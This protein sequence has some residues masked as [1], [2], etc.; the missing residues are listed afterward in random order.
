[1]HT[2]ARSKSAYK[3]YQKDKEKA[4]KK[5]ANPNIQAQQQQAA[6][7][8]SSDTP[9]GPVSYTKD[10]PKQVCVRACACACT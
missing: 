7:A 2:H 1:M 6:A 5:A 10:E 3:K 4:A 8:E 9:A